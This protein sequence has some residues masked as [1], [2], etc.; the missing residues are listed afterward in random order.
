[1]ATK[2]KAKGKRNR[3]CCTRG[4]PCKCESPNN[5]RTICKPAWTGPTGAELPYTA[6]HVLCVASVKA[7]IV[8]RRGLAP[9]VKQTRWCVNRK[10]NMVA[11]PLWGHTV[12]WYH[13]NRNTSPP[14]R[15][16]TQH[17]WDHNG[18]G[19]YREEVE[20]SLDGL[21]DNVA[22][23]KDKHDDA[24]IKDLK[25]GL[26]SRSQQFK[27]RLKSRGRRRGGTHKQ[28]QD[29]GKNARWHEPFSMA[30]SATSKGYPK[31]DW[32]RSVLDKVRRFFA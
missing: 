18:D 32:R 28:F 6:H 1:M 23:A 8:K 27:A 21:A 7:C 2:H 3:F 22:D 25:G 13:K 31:Q 5:Y 9:I 10:G 26:N 19:S 15:N 17:D 4:T 11:L 12:K 29:E 20:A 14:F 24:R 16:L 30:A